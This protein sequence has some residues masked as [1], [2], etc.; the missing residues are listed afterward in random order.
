MNLDAS[1]IDDLDHRDVLMWA[2]GA[3]S[4]LVAFVIA[5]GAAQ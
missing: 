4:A 1:T 2:G 3:A 5:S